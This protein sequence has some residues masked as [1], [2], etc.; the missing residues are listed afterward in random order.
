MCDVTSDVVRW[1][2]SVFG[3]HNTHKT[4]KTVSR[5]AG[6]G[7][8]LTPV[9]VAYRGVIHNRE[10]SGGRISYIGILRLV[11]PF[12]LPNLA[13]IIKITCRGQNGQIIT[14]FLYGGGV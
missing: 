6:E 10:R 8:P 3:K 5:W 11:I 7:E 14:Q 13:L 2:A 9:L 12:V 1:T 4:N